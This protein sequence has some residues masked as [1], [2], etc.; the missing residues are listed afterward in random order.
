MMT[1]VIVF[2]MNGLIENEEIKYGK[3]VFDM[4]GSLT[5]I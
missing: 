2:R 3:P 1:T 5:D 4:A